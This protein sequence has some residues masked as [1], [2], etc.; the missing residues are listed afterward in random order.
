M[1]NTTPE[2]QVA[3]EPKL[4]EWADMK[5]RCTCGHE[6]TLGE[7][8]Q[9]GIRFDLYA[10]DKH[11]LGLM[12]ESC[13]TK[14]EL[15]FV[16]ATNPPKEEEQDEQSTTEQVEEPAETADAAHGGGKQESATV[17][18]G[19]VEEKEI[20]NESVSETSKA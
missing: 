1:S 18:A 12:C 19:Q 17:E 10:T 5:L 13:S 8:I 6:Q 4:F 3:Q 16:E 9:G 7:N 20:K 2:V 11:T 15:F 14:L